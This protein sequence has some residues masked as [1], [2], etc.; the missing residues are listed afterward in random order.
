MKNLTPVFL[1]LILIFLCIFFSL[2]LFL[3]IDLLPPETKPAETNETQAA[4]KEE[5]PEEPIDW[6]DVIFPALP[7]QQEA[8]QAPGANQ[9]PET[10]PQKIYTNQQ[11]NALSN[12]WIPYG[13]GL[14]S[15]GDPA[16]YAPDAQKQYGKYNAHF[17]E[18]EENVIYLTFDCGYEVLSDGKSVTGMILDTLKEKGVKAV[19]FV[20]GTFVE[21]NPAI[22]QRIIDEGHAL[23]N[24]SSTH[25][26]LPGLSIG[27]MEDQIMPLHNQVKDEFGYTMKFF[28]PPEGAFSL[29]SLAVTQNLGYET[30][31]WSFAYADWDTANQ[32]DPQAALEKI[33]DCHHDGAIYL[34]HAVSTT[35]AQILG[36]VIDG[37]RAMGYRLDLLS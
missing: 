37:L 13:P 23:G 4:Q 29:R 1:V 31:H 14:A 15:N 3:E 7:E 34:L 35:N 25:A 12:D 6:V 26:A 30:V 33:L 20:T 5:P 19:F 27:E 8:T 16:P 17:I 9:A 10:D 24:H 18:E 28:R 22:V 11:L 36:D 2:R 21:K 32:P